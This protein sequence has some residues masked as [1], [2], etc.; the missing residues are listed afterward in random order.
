MTSKIFTKGLIIEPMQIYREGQLEV[1]S[2]SEGYLVCQSPLLDKNHII[3][4]ARMTSYWWIKNIE[5]VRNEILGHSWGF[6][7]EGMI[8]ECVPHDFPT[9][10]Y[11]VNEIREGWLGLSTELDKPEKERILTHLVHPDSSY[12]TQRGQGVKGMDNSDKGSCWKVIRW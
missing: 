8:I 5:Q 11:V 7:K 12:E 10:M 4:N 6:F 3:L 1:K 2:A 9:V